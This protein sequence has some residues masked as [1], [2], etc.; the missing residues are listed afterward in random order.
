MVGKQLNK[1]FRLNAIN[2]SEDYGGFSTHGGAADT[3]MTI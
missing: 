1:R 3:A 2:C